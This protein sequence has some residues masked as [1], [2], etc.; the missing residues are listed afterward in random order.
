MPGIRST[1]IAVPLAFGLLLCGCLQIGPRSVRRDQFDYSTAVADAWKEQMLLNIVKLRYVDLPVFVDVS[2]IVSGY[3]LETSIEAGGSVSSGPDDSF[4]DVGASGTFTDR[5]TLTYTPKTGNDFLQ[6]LMVPIDPK[7]IFLLVQSGYSASFIF[8]WALEAVNG[9]RNRSMAGGRMREPDPEFV[10][11]LELIG[12]A[13]AEGAFGVRVEETEEKKEATVVFFR[14]E[15]LPSEVQEQM[16]QAKRTVG[17]PDERDRFRVVF[18]PVRGSDEELTVQTRSMLQI[19]IAMATFI[20]APPEHVA[21]GRAVNGVPEPHS[22]AHPM[23][24]HSGTDEPE[25]AF[26]AIRYADHW[27]WIENGDVG[28]KRS[29][30]LVTFLFA[31]SGASGAAGAPI[32]TIPAG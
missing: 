21:S 17:I 10:R 5:P 18:S 3:S 8:E 27:F 6:A 13:Q 28:S 22:R 12:T 1:R 9:V 24:I 4:L 23:R 19:L 31:L 20:D 15:N 7:A 29:F 11:L 32:L 26:A 2:Q 14:R 25:D 16:L 30:F